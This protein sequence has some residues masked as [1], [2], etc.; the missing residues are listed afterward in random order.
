[1]N[2]RNIVLPNELS[3]SFKENKWNTGELVFVFGFPDLNPTEKLKKQVCAKK[4]TNNW[5]APIL[6]GL[7]GVDKNSSKHTLMAIK[8]T[9]FLKYYELWYCRFITEP[10]FMFLFSPFVTKYVCFT[11]YIRKKRAVGIIRTQNC[12][13]IN[14]Q[15]Y[16]NYNDC[17]YM[18]SEMSCSFLFRDFL[19]NCFT[20]A[21]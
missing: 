15:M 8:S 3:W 4:L 20:H 13:E 21:V 7:G 1:M 11:Q 14:N 19:F 18:F 10:N 9:S 16:V 2:W 12:C 6:S 5:T 17:N